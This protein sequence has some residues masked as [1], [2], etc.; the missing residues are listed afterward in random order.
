PFRGAV[1]CVPPAITGQAWGR[2]CAGFSPASCIPRASGQLHRCED[3]G[4]ALLLWH[5]LA[6]AGYR[7]GDSDAPPTG[8]FAG[9]SCPRGGRATAQGGGRSPAAHGPPCDLFGRFAHV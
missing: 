1:Q 9:G 3:G 4:A 7:R 8:S 6:V 2:A 5:D